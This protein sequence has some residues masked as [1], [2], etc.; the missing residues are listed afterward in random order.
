VGL[1]R[2]RSRSPSLAA[3]QMFLLAEAACTIVF[4]YLIDLSM[5]MIPECL[6]GCSLCG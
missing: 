2:T 4:D 5:D 3:T 1:T 6:L